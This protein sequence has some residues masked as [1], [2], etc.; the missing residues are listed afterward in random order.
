MAPGDKREADLQGFAPEKKKAKADHADSP[1][2][3]GRDFKDTRASSKPR[4]T[5]A[6][7]FPL[8]WVPVQIPRSGSGRFRRTGFRSGA[9]GSG[10]EGPGAE[11]VGAEGSCQAFGDNI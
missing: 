7:C 10:A 9:Q 11:G 8:R 3:S 1:T 4:V 2:E 5:S 6:S